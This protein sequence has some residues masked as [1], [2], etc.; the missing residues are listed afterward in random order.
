MKEKGIIVSLKD[1][2]YIIAPTL[3]EACASC[4][5]TCDKKPTLFE[6][7]NPQNLPVKVGSIVEFEISRRSQNIQGLL[8]LFVPFL[9]A[10]MG[11][12]LAKPAA[13]LFGKTAGEGLQALFVLIFLFGSAITMFIITRKHPLPG[14]IQI[15]SLG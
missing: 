11:Y 13:A 12:I 6:A 15:V 4:T 10:V 2:K 14:K 7:T 1:Q 9:C 8:S 5:G 3:S